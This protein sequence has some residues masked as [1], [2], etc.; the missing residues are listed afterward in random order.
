VL[1]LNK[2]G[3]SLL[4]P[5]SFMDRARV[6]LIATFRSCLGVAN[7]AFTIKSICMLI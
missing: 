3:I 6:T 7:Q 2:R 5:T 1:P 4:D